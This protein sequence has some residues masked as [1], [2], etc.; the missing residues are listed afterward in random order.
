MHRDRRIN[1][2]SHK[3]T[4]DRLPPSHLARC[5]PPYARRHMPSVQTLLV[6]HGV[7]LRPFGRMLYAMPPFVISERELRCITSGMRAVVEATERG[8]LGEGVPLESDVWRT[9]AAARAAE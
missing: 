5:A 1:T 6:Q 3:H 4:L 8:A 2:R 9:A 7:W